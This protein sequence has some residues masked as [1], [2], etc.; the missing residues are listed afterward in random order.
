MTHRA[1]RSIAARRARRGFTPV[2]L[3]RRRPKYHHVGFRKLEPCPWLAE[4]PKESLNG[5]WLVF[6]FLS[7]GVRYRAGRWLDR[8]SNLHFLPWLANSQMRQWEE[9]SHSGYTPYSDNLALTHTHSGPQTHVH[10]T[11]LS[12]QCLG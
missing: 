2:L 9:I 5:S 6:F 11:P 1:A 4:E 3:S 10:T 7:T 8:D 12:P